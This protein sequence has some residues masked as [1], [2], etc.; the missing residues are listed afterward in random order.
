MLR[1]SADLDPAAE[2]VL[3]GRYEL[4]EPIG[5]GGMSTVY[6]ARDRSLGRPVA[7]KLIRHAP[8]GHGD[9]EQLRQRFR[10]EA[11]NAARIPPHPNVVQIYDYGTD[12]ERDLDFIVM[13]LLR[14]QDL[15]AALRERPFTPA[16]T[17][18]ILLEAA[19]GLAAGH[20]AGIV[21]RDV[22]PANFVLMQEPAGA[23]VKVLDF[24]I[25]KA[26]EGDAEDDL[27]QAGAAPHTPA[28]ASPEQLS[29]RDALSPAS[30]VYQLG[31]VAYEL[32]TG[33]RAFDAK[34]RERI[35][36]GEPVPLQA[37]GNWEQVPLPL[38][39]VVE[40]A[41]Q[42]NPRERY[43]DAGAF[44]EA[45]AGAQEDDHTLLASAAPLVTPIEA[46][47]P[48]AKPRS[49]GVE[50]IQRRWFSLPRKARIAVTALV[51]VLLLWSVFRGWGDTS[52][53][54][55]APLDSRGTAELEAEFAPLFQQASELLAETDEA[56]P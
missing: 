6:R 31:L 30:D 21:H 11:A 9:L 55:E 34:D 12:P 53:E 3:V 13:E 49:S 41:L 20:R 38:R 54:S 46:A 10:R 48:A 33:Q 44:A 43:P 42:S 16:E 47:P 19:R 25:A 23:S 50:S 32:F 35:A 52:A 8:A 36:T 4:Q 17:V 5:Q 26:L 29:G 56:R 22:K 2:D 24:G 45:L 27:T 14:G 51:A 40:R 1:N 37:R 7:V 28:Y 18:R 15:K 39:R